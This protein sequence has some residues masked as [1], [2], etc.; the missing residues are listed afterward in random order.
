MDRAKLI[1]YSIS[2]LFMAICFGI[3][4]WLS[5]VLG[6]AMSYTMAVFFA[7]GMIWFG[8]NVKNIYKEK[9]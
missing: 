6:D 1:V 4:V 9:Q 5:V 3:S 7:V 2:L 8:I